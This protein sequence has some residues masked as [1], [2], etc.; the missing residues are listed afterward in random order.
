MR[1]DQLRYSENVMDLSLIVPTVTFLDTFE[2]GVS[3]AGAYDVRL[4]SNTPE[5]E[6]VNMRL[7]IVN[8]SR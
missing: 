7:Q 6:A 3:A 1:I 2:D 8:V 5:G 4:V